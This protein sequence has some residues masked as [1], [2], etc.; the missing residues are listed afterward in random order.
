MS[1]TTQRGKGTIK[2]WNE[3]KGYGFITFTEGKEKADIF[4]HATGV[5]SGKDIL[6][7]GLEVEFE[8]TEGKKGLIATNVQLCRPK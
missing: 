6:E 7:Q 2:M 1:T 4:V 3:Q 8:I 5:L